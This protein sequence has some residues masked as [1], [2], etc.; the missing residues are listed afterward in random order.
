MSETVLDELVIRLG[1]DTSGLQ[2]SAQQALGVL[3]QLEQKTN[4]LTGKN[5]KTTNQ[6]GNRF[7]QLQK[8]AIG[9]LGLISAGR[10]VSDILKQST[11]E[12][13]TGENTRKQNQPS[14]KAEAKFATGLTHFTTPPSAF[15]S[16]LSTAP[17]GLEPSLSGGEGLPFLYHS[18]QNNLT[19]PVSTAPANT[20]LL[21]QPLEKMA[22]YPISASR[23]S[24]RSTS[25][26]VTLNSTTIIA[27]HNAPLTPIIPRTV[28]IIS[29][30]NSS[31][32]LTSFHQLPKDGSLSQ[33]HSERLPRP[34]FPLSGE[35]MGAGTVLP[36]DQSRVN[37]RG[38]LSRQGAPLAPFRQPDVQSKNAQTSI[39]LSK[40]PRPERQID[41]IRSLP[42]SHQ[43][44]QNGPN[45]NTQ[46]SDG[47]SPRKAYTPSRHAI[48][49]ASPSTPFPPN[50]RL[51]GNARN[52]TQPYLADGAIWRAAMVPQSGAAAASVQ[53]TTHIGPVT[54]HVPSGNPQDI[55]QAVC[56]L[57]RENS[58]TLTSLATY[59]AV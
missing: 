45:Q 42:K 34:D 7:T 46:Q 59:G 32:L 1:L 39:A 51:P 43:F 6:I 50:A 27:R 47:S 9:L 25:P 28:P 23:L 8:Q 48:E 29:A 56:T 12:N 5:Q 55:A 4:D 54:I 3:D 44:N 13:H 21:R 36:P 24:E 37:W 15:R 20:S 31:P 19:P 33:R 2:T 11:L 41:Q 49:R 26:R 52:T 16:P 10:G 38:F 22:P 35:Q 53:N 14:R 17:N 57:G 40:M 30:Q 18:T 58:H